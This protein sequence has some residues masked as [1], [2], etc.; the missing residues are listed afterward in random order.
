MNDETL[1]QLLKDADGTF[2]PPPHA[3][4][5]AGAVR[6]I[7]RRRRT[8]AKVLAG[9]SVVGLAVGGAWWKSRETPPTIVKVDRPVVEDLR[10]ELDAAR[11]DAEVRTAAVERMLAREKLAVRAARAD[12]MLEVL[13]ERDR[14]AAALLYRGDRHR[15]DMRPAEAA[16]AYRRV[17]ELFPASLVAGEARKRLNEI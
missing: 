13:L 9:A 17:I 6:W 12:A 1:G 3:G 7:D 15:Q 8:R 11:A 4:D 16:D 10:A 14:A 5:V 2:T